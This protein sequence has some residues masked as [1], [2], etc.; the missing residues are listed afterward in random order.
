MA[1]GLEIIQK[2]MKETLALM[3]EDNLSLTDWDV[4]IQM[5][6]VGLILHKIG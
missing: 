2:D 5:A 3:S 6:T 4:V 1:M